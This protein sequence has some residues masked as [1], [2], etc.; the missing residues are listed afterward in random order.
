MQRVNFLE[1]LE[2]NLKSHLNLILKPP[3]EFNESAIKTVS[4]KEKYLIWEQMISRSTVFKSRYNQ[5]AGSDEAETEWVSDEN[6]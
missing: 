2:D 1:I 3:K 5:P 6:V 4:E